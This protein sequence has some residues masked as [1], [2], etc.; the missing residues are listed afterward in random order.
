[1]FRN[2]DG[3]FYKWLVY[4][5]ALGLVFFWGFRQWNTNQKMQVKFL[6]GEVQKEGELS[7]VETIVLIK[8]HLAGDVE[9]PGLYS[10]P[11]GARL[12]DL[13]HLGSPRNQEM[14]DR[15]CNRA[16]ML[17]DGQK[18]YVPAPG[19]VPEK[20]QSLPGM[21][22]GKININRADIQEL[23]RLPGIGEKKASDIVYYREKNG[24]FKKIDDIIN[25]TGIGTTT[26]ERIKDQITIQM[27]LFFCP[28]H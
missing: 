12:E 4:L 21:E 28:C 15:H 23:T 16:A 5:L 17:Q 20:I 18:I 2:E 26:F 27:L 13:L 11:E 19:E 3:K 24:N 6:E 9:K 25:V 14:V 10:L 22:K 8:V 1:M 7:P